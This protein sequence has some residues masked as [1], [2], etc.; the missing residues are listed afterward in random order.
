MHD[1]GIP[2]GQPVG[3]G[4]I[5]VVLTGQGGLEDGLGLRCE[6]ACTFFIF[7]MLIRAATQTNGAR[8]AYI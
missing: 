5:F 6:D 1:I 3:G 2:V 8:M 4:E 7:D